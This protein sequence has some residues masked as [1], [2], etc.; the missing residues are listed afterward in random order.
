MDFKKMLPGALTA[1]SVVGVGVSSIVTA[2]CHEK[3]LPKIVRIKEENPD[4]SKTDLVKGTWKCYI[5][6]VTSVVATSAAIIASHRLSAS[7]LA[8]M[9]AAAAA[10][11]SQKE[12][13]KNK[14]KNAIGDEK[15]AKVEKSLADDTTKSFSDANKRKD[16]ETLF[17]DTFTNEAF[18]ANVE[19]VK[20]AIY[21]INRI[22]AIDGSV[23][24]GDFYELIGCKKPWYGDEYGWSMDYGVSNQ[25]YCW[26]DINLERNEQIDGD[27]V[28]YRIN[29]VIE[30][31]TSFELDAYKYKDTSAVERANQVQIM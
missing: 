9:T 27:N 22:M 4:A 23:S 2:K 30:P 26:I 14:V 11:I 28:Y 6:A 10:A 15:W 20:D 8:S 31:S 3:A 19:A 21:K 7:Q 12:K 13:I 24:L 5:P 18:Y 1:L 16:N 17:Y 25:N 29:Y